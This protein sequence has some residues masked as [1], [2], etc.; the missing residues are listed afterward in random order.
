MTSEGNFPFEVMFVKKNL[1]KI[2]LFEMSM[3]FI[4]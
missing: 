4:E 3:V 2:S 1:S